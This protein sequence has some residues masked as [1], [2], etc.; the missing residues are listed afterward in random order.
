ML[1]VQVAVRKSWLSGRIH[2]LS[3]A[4]PALSRFHVSPVD[5]F[6]VTLRA[7]FAT[8]R[9]RQARNGPAERTPP[10]SRQNAIQDA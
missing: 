5:V 1:L 9:C 8:A 4:T 6:A 2:Y 3:D 7:S 10:D